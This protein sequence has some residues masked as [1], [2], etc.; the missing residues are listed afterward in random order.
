MTI[1]LPVLIG[2]YRVAFKWLQGPTTQT[3]VNVMHINATTGTSA[4]ADV[5]EALQD[6]VTAAMWTGVVNNASVDTVDITPLDGVSGTTSFSTG[7]GAIWTG[8]SAG[9]FVVAASMLV[10]FQTGVRGRDNRG[11]MFL[12]FISENGIANGF[13]DPTNMAV[14]QAAFVAFQAALQ[15]D[16]GPSG[17]FNHVVAAYDR[18]HSGVG[19]HITPVTAYVAESAQG[20]MRRRQQRLR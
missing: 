7:S 16:G 1:P 10:K 2:T 20:T 17:P 14:C 19:A 9:Q 11:R 4:S 13:C 12:P 15:A 18:R 8:Q 5:F 6:A 3:A